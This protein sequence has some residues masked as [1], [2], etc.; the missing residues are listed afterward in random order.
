MPKIDLRT[1][2]GAKLRIKEL[3]KKVKACDDL[4]LSIIDCIGSVG[5]SDIEFKRS[6]DRL[7]KSIDKYKKITI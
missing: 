7:Q 1:L 3:E 6:L 4:F 2:S 5:D